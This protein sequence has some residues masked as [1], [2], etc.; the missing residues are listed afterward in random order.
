[1]ASILGARIK[2]QS[3]ESARPPT[4]SAWLMFETGFTEVWVVGMLIRWIRVSDKPIA[5]LAKP[6]GSSLSGVPGKTIRNIK[7]I[8]HSHTIAA[9]ILY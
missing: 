9:N 1:M 2:S 4:N 6:L 3:C 5:N 7:V 8:T